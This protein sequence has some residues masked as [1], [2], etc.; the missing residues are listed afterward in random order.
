MK[1][2]LKGFILLVVFALGFLITKNY[3]LP[4]IAGEKVS[5][6]NIIIPKKEVI[7]FLPYW[8]ISKAQTDYSKYITN[9][10]YF[11]LALGED[12]AIQQYT[13]P[14][15]S[16]PGYYSL[17]SGKVDTQLSAAKENGV[18]LSLAVFSGDDKV[19]TE[20]LN[21]PETS[22]TNLVDSVSP[23]MEKYGFTGLNLDIEQVSDASPEAR[24]KYVRFVKSVSEQVNSK[25]IK[26][27]SVDVTA[28]SFVKETNLVDPGAVE[29]YVD[30]IIIMA[31]DYHYTGSYV[32][33]PVAPLSGAGSFS[34]FDTESA[35]EAALKTVPSNKIILG[36]PLYGYSW[37]TI[38]TIPRSAVIPASGLSMS[39]KKVEDFLSTCASCSAT[40]DEVDKENYLIYQDE[41]TKTY[42]Q[43]FYPDKKSTEYKVKLAK[44]NSLSGIALWALGYED[45]TILEPLASYHN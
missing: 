32:T 23:I 20:I 35:I 19:I 4:K 33:G 15:E 40:F 2:I 38:G 29:Q 6:V 36:V 14:G 10:T 31:Y 25:I 9:L 26:T 42:Y 27:L 7:G 24:L 34:E 30:K 41:E 21:N 37:E 11:S 8:L 18:D 45:S 13:N 44:S 16:E 28:S 22:A 43:I 39:S 12:G 3:I 17:I 5:V 1:N